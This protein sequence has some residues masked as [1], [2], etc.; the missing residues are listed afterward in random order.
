MVDWNAGSFG[1]SDLTLDEMIL[2]DV[3]KGE[4]LSHYRRRLC[5]DHIRTTMKVSE[6]RA[7][8]VT[9]RDPST[10]CKKETGA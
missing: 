6:R 10:Q 9:G 2:A 4:F 7:C 8:V 5:I 3:A 1:I